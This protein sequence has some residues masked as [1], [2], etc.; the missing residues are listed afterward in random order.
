MSGDGRPLL[1]IRDLAVSFAAGGGRVQALDG[2]SL[3]IHPRQTLAVVGESGC[4]KSVTALSVLQLVPR[5]PGRIDRGSILFE[6]R[7]LLSLSERQMR[8]VRGGRIAMIFQEPMTSLNPVY[9]VGDQ[10]KEAVSL[11]QKVS[12][13]E[14]AEAAIDALH[15]VGISRPA[16]RLR[17][18]P[19]QFSGGMLQRAM[20]AMALACRPDLLL[21][22]EPTT[23]LDVTIQAQILRLLS[24]LQH[25]HRMALMLIS[26]DLGVVAQHADVVC[27]VY[28]GRVVEYATVF[29]LFEKPAHPY[30]RG[31]LESIPRLGEARPRLS[32]VDQVVGDPRQFEKGPGGGEG[33]VA[34]WP[35]HP[36]PPGLARSSGGGDSVLHEVEPGHWIRCWRTERLEQRPGRPPDIGFRRGA[37]PG[38]RPAAD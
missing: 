35:A 17:E 4:G 23:A 26:H 21:A 24:D 13:R 28:A 11:H 25:R 12:G 19:H 32:T 5:P 36:P 18:Y 22:D 38:A 31:L 7:D 16:Q 20:I 8:E 33:V 2:L 30:T 15:E 3:T 34:W 27:V 10:I 1:D 29:D 37:Q 9:T 6:G 14:A